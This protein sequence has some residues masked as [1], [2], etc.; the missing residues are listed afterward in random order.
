MSCSVDEI[1]IDDDFEKP[2]AFALLL[3]HQFF[4]LL[5]E[6]QTVLDQRISD[7]LSKCL[8]SGHSK[9]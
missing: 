6:Q 8:Y 9:K 4:D 7:A 5:A 3:L 1:L 2:R